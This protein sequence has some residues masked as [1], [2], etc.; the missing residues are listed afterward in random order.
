MCSFDEPQRR[1]FCHAEG[2]GNG[3][4]R[5]TTNLGS[6]WGGS[7]TF[8]RTL[9]WGQFVNE[10][11]VQ[12]EECQ[13]STCSL[14]TTTIDVDLQRRGNC[15]DDFTGWFTTFLIDDISLV[16]QVGQPG[17][18]RSND[19]KPHGYIRVPDRNANIEVRL[20][21]DA[22]L[23][24]GSQDSESG[25][26]QVTLSFNSPCEG[27]WFYFGHIAI[28]VP[29][30]KALLPQVGDGRTS[31]LGRPLEMRAGD[32]IGTRIGTS[33]N[34]GL[35]FGVI[36]QRPRLL[37]YQHPD[38]YSYEPYGVCFYDFFGAEI[39]STLRN[40]VGGESTD[41]DFC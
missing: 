22:T 31:S 7:I 27:V 32:V 11:Q 39:A 8:E 24:A 9:K 30:I 15:P 35:D 38:A 36:D 14:T 18:I 2:Q 23:F 4:L 6:G 16:T 3:Q 21:V 13:G 34:A 28:T 25:E 5:W 33:G 37:T 26:I 17:Q 41:S 20:P 12:L 19:Y 10:I 40:R 1:L 29:E